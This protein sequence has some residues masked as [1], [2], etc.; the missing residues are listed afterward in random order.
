[1]NSKRQNFCLRYKQIF[2]F[3]QD[4]VI[5]DFKFRND[6]ENCFKNKTI[7]HPVWSMKIMIVIYIYIY[8]GQRWD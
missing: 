2:S 7:R 1:M 5:R 6:S 4:Y 3:V 8:Q